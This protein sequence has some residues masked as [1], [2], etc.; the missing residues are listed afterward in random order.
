MAAAYLN[1]L[2]TDEAQNLAGKHFYRPRNPQIAAR[3][4]DKLRALPMVT[5]DVDFGGWTKA[6]KIHF[7]DGGTFDQIYGAK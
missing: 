7:D 6:Q 5:V 3:F 1:F 4:A 2:Y